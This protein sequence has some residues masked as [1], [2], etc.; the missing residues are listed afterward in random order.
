MIPIAAVSVIAIVF[1]VISLKS[2]WDQ[3]S[4]HLAMEQELAR[5]N[6]PS[7]HEVSGLAP[8]LRLAP[9]SVRGSETENELIPL[10]NAEFAELDLLWTQKERFRSYRATI[11]R[12]DSDE[13]FN[14]PPLQLDN[15][16]N[17]IRLRLPARLLNPGLYQIEISGVAADGAVSPAE[18][19]TFE[20][21]K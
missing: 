18:E 12:Y 19:Y 6:G 2:R 14:V 3:R 7:F 5:L 17:M 21:P 8:P 10:A 11:R 15:G 13:R 20:V 9:G 16:T 1:A 4:E